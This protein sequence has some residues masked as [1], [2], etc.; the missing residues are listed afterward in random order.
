VIGYLIPTIT[1]YYP[2]ADVETTMAAVAF[3]QITPFV[4]NI[5]WLLFS[6]RVGNPDSSNTG[7]A[8][9]DAPY[10]KRIY[11]TTFATSVLS[12][13]FTLYLCF[14]RY[15]S[16]TYIFLPREYQGMSFENA[17]NFIFQVDFWIIFLATMVWCF[18]AVWDIKRLGFM[19]VGLLKA[20]VSIGL[21]AVV[22][23]P[24]AVLSAVWW[25]REEKI[26][27]DDKKEKGKGK[28]AN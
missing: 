5:L 25:W 13:F 4:V 9:N 16:F 27:V 23:G 7:N 15:V 12:H 18:Q 8:K 28:L 20:A 21:G 3:W 10:L 6:F 14:S 17:M 24:G 22:V 11:A 26:R 19:N 1:I 2:F